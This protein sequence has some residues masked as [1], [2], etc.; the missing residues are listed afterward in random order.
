M[1]ME[2]Q[3]LQQDKLLEF[4]GALVQDHEVIAPVSEGSSGGLSY[5][6]IDSAAE[7]V[8]PRDARR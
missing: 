7:M 4:I 2:A 1:T 6:K 5:G 8:H 3:I